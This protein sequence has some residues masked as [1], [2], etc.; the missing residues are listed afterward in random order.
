MSMSPEMEA[1][2]DG[3]GFVEWAALKIEF[4]DRTVRLLDRAGY[5][6]LGGGEIYT[7]EDEVYGVWVSGDDISDGVDSEAPRFQ[8]G[9][10]ISDPAVAQSLVWPAT[11]RQMSPV[12]VMTGLVD[13]ETGDPLPGWETEFVGYFDTSVRRLDT[14]NDI[15]VVECDSFSVFEY[16]MEN[17]EGVRLNGPWHKALHPGELGLDLVIDVEKTLPWGTGGAGTEFSG[18]GAGPSDWTQ[19]LSPITRYVTRA[20]GGM[21]YVMNPA[22]TWGRTLRAML[23]DQ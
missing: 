2:Y 6:D 4:P 3:D 14:D 22:I 23:G 1:A 21:G 11:G 7:G 18:K 16:L 13:P 8:F 5:L 15:D 12:T 20:Q 10:K 19:G 17:S 9:L